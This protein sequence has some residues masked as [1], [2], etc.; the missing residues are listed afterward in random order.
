MHV[1][2]SACY[3]LQLWESKV[4]CFGSIH[5]CGREV[6]SSEELSKSI[7]EAKWKPDY[8]PSEVGSAGASIIGSREALI[9]YNVNLNTTNLEIGEIKYQE[10]YD[11]YAKIIA[12][13]WTGEQFSLTKD[14]KDYSQISEVERKTVERGG[15]LLWSFLK[16]SFS[17][18]I[19]SSY[20]ISRHLSAPLLLLP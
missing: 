8:G 11:Y 18:I 20:L 17:I 5:E 9:A 4:K 16:V 1:K 6:R 19:T 10:V 3:F 13:N 12:N 14:E 7:G 15:L 2:R